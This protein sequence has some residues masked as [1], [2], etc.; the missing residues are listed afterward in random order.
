[1]SDD[2]SAAREQFTPG[3]IALWLVAMTC[4]LGQPIAEAFELTPA[5]MK[6]F[7]V[8]PLF[9]ALCCIGLVRSR[10][11]F[12]PAEQLLSPEAYAELRRRSVRR[13]FRVCFWV[14]LGYTGGALVASGRVPAAALV[15]IGLALTLLVGS[16]VD[17]WTRR[18]GGWLP[19]GGSRR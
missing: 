7:K 9:V 6:P 5:W 17:L 15:L 1:M 8:S 19:T 3:Q 10:W 16:A 18:R 12:E 4:L 11:L 13:A 14:A 2:S